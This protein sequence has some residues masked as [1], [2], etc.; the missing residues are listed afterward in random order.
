M[1]DLKLIKNKIYVNLTDIK[2]C[3]NIF[4]GVFIEK[5][6]SK[7][8]IC[9]AD[10]IDIKHVVSVKIDNH[11]PNQIIEFIKNELEIEGITILDKELFLKN[12]KG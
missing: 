2:Q 9:G 11:D 12:L 5:T 10:N 1:V 8:L 3:E 7:I 6:N 4:G